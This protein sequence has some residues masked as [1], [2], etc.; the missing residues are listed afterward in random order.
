MAGNYPNEWNR[1]IDDRLALSSVGRSLR[2]TRLPPTMVRDVIGI[3][4]RDEL[5]IREMRPV[6]RATSNVI[7]NP[8]GGET[9]AIPT[10]RL[11]LEAILSN[12]YGDYLDAQSAQE[13]R[14]ATPMDIDDEVV[15]G[16]V[17]DQPS[18]TI[19]GANWVTHIVTLYYFTDGGN[20]QEENFRVRLNMNNPANQD[21]V[22]ALSSG[23]GRDQGGPVWDSLNELFSIAENSDLHE[24]FGSKGKTMEA[25]AYSD[26][27]QYWKAS[28]ETDSGVNIDDRVVTQLTG[29]GVPT[30]L[31]PVF[32]QAGYRNPYTRRSFLLDAVRVDNARITY[33]ISKEDN[34]TDPWLRNNILQDCCWLNSI[35]EMVNVRMQ[36]TFFTYEKLWSMMGKFGSFDPA[37]AR[38]GLSIKDMVPLFELLDRSVNVY[39]GEDKL[40]YQRLRTTQKYNHILPHSWSFAMTEHHIYPLET[41]RTT[42]RYSEDSL[43]YEEYVDE[44]PYEKISPMLP[45]QILHPPALLSELKNPKSK[46][47]LLFLM[48]EGCDQDGPA[49]YATLHDILFSPR[50]ADQDL[51]VV[52]QGNMI[53]DVILELICKYKYRPS[54]YGSGF[55]VTCVLVQS[56]SDRGKIKFLNPIGKALC[57][58]RVPDASPSDDFFQTAEEYIQYVQSQH[59]FFS[60]IASKETLSV[61]HESTA[62]LLYMNVRGGVFGWTVPK[63]AQP[64]VLSSVK[65][66]SSLDVN[67]IYPSALQ[68]DRVPVCTVFDFF[69]PIQGD[70]HSEL[71]KLNPLDLLLVYAYDTPTL[72][73]DRGSSLC[74]VCNFKSFLQRE[75]VELVEFD[76][77]VSQGS[78]LS[79]GKTYVKICAVLRTETKPSKAWHSIASVWEGPMSRKLKKKTLVRGIG[80]LGESMNV[81][82]R[83]ANIFCNPEEATIFAEERKGSVL[84]IEDRIFLA[85]TEGN[86][87]PRLEGW[88][89]IHLYV[90]DVYR[91][92]L[93]HWYDKLTNRGIRVLYV[94]C[95]EF[96]FDSKDMKK[97]LDIVY[98]GDCDSL[99]AFGLLKV[100]YQ[101]KSA[102]DIGVKFSTHSVFGDYIYPTEKYVECFET[103]VKYPLESGRFET[104]MIRPVPNEYQVSNIK[105]YYR[106]LL[107]A[108][109]P[110]AGKSHTVLSNFSDVVVVCPTNALCVEFQK[111]YPGC[112][113]LTLHRFLR[114]KLDDNKQT[115]EDNDF[116]RKKHTQPENNRVLL[117]DEIY[118]YSFPLLTKLYFRLQITGATRV[119][120]TGDFNQLPPVSEEIS[121]ELSMPTQAKMKRMLAIEYLFP[122]VMNL[123]ICKRGNTPLENKKIQDMA[124]IIRSPGY[125]IGLIMEEV[126]KRIQGI[127]YVVAIEK[128]KGDL[129]GNIAVCYYNLTCSRIA[130]NVLP[131]GTK[132]MRDVRLVN[133]ARRSCKGGILMVNYEYIVDDVLDNQVVL[134]D[135]LD[136]DQT[137]TVPTSHVEHK[138]H[139]SQTR[140]CH[141][142]QGSS[143]S[144]SLI[145]FNLK[146]KRISPEFLYVALTRARSMNEIFFVTDV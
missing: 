7:V 33:D 44:H 38:S 48:Q 9:Y 83:K 118:M 69:Q 146:S 29:R 129:Y 87:V 15:A 64:C 30:Q 127:P 104:K 39:D 10:T 131:N 116:L 145:I 141:S 115:D 47:R 112:M 117:L 135:V 27:K 49:D 137:F 138:M 65:K 119:F 72:Y 96:F 109:V 76:S 134:R 2:S 40:V 113:A 90:L 86:R 21:I 5:G 95:D 56:L 97:A 106:L 102:D 43:V 136:P 37:E 71:D 132:L 58:G 42:L 22:N 84:P 98:D 121:E 91:K 110:G 105:D 92:I 143:V 36:R 63:A 12:I 46:L 67:R 14:M 3:I 68:C 41:G 75:N 139:W 24:F 62:N 55:C 35:I 140:T 50:Y 8:I 88:Y 128:M 32:E 107:T 82:Q 144:S 130:K 142:L 73:L 20:E 4:V 99:D 78:W 126:Q 70:V 16:N 100:G 23:L 81:N 51:H 61:F 133:R 57:S 111:K 59:D 26:G 93:Q 31:N 123:T 28:I 60:S 101:N 122:N 114:L 6:T 85:F 34:F 103:N 13:S 74:Y 45:N 108:S 80:K 25:W 77:M 94:R 53:D 120:A 125:N 1:V 54:I 19:V 17:Q 66:F 11:E 79:T 124:T 89:L 52:V 18:G